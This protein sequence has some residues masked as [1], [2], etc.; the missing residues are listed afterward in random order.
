MFAF[1]TLDGKFPIIH[2]FNAGIYLY[3]ADEARRFDGKETG[4]ERFVSGQK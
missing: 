2:Q 4:A 3:E 1:R